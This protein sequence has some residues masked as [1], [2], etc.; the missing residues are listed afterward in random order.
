MICHSK[1]CYKCGV[2]KDTSHFSKHKRYSDG[3]Q[4]ECKECSKKYTL[5]AK[6]VIRIKKQ[7]WYQK[8]KFKISK[9][10]YETNRTN[11]RI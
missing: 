3:L 8:N 4:K 1:K 9:K 6:E 10:Y 7:I 11:T 5:E 2:N